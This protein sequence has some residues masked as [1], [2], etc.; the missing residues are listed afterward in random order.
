MKNLFYLNLEN[1]EFL[2]QK[3]STKNYIKCFKRTTGE[4]FFA[5]DSGSRIYAARQKPAIKN[6]QSFK[7][8]IA[9]QNKVNHISLDNLQSTN[10][11]FFKRDLIIKV[12][13]SQTLF[14]QNFL[15]NHQKQY[16]DFALRYKEGFLMLKHAKF[17]TMLILKSRKGGFL[18]RVAGFLCFIPKK[19]FLE[20][21]ISPAHGDFV[22]LEEAK[23]MVLFLLKICFKLKTG[24]DFFYYL[25]KNI[26]LVKGLLSKI[27]LTFNRSL[28][29]NKI[30]LAHFGVK[31]K[32][33][34]LTS[35][36]KKN[37]VKSIKK[38]QLVKGQANFILLFKKVRFKES[39]LISEEVRAKRI[40]TLLSKQ[41][42]AISTK[43]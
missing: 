23:F 30:P 12:R 39:T 1:K 43:K 27:K 25:N 11:V 38:R 8:A 4:N 5:L 37:L 16:V 32:T 15:L 33:V 22:M 26:F 36:Y 7:R 17:C 29:L 19:Y 20:A 31:I 9:P 18:A 10:T 6:Q 41:M 40:K 35:Y 3:C 42:Y 2:K 21:L 34:I 14:L 24:Y 13:F 28:F